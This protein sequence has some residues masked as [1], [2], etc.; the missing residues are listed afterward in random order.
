[1]S[2]PLSCMILMSEGGRP[3]PAIAPESVRLA[4]T[5]ALQVLRGLLDEDGAFA[6]VALDAASRPF[7]CGPQYLPR[8][9]REAIRE[10]V[11]AWEYRRGQA[12]E[13]ISRVVWPMAKERRPGREILAEAMRAN[14]THGAPLTMN[15]VLAE[16]RAIAAASLRGSGHARGR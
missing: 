4:D 15:E 11:R 7:N 3:M 9:C 8:F 14:R 10:G 12:L 16:C 1:M 5:L 2:V 6:A 13:R